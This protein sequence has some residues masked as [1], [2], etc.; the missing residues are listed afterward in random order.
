MGDLSAYWCRRIRERIEHIVVCKTVGLEFLCGF[1]CG[2]HD[3]ADYDHHD[4][5]DHDHNDSSD[6]DHYG[7]ADH[8]HND[9]SD[10]HHHDKHDHNDPASGHDY[11]D[12]AKD[13]EATP[14]KEKNVTGQYLNVQSSRTA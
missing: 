12:P 1:D 8:D 2:R 7:S 9:S 6:Y 13:Q 14:S 10:Y 11:N 5:A 3:S 4:G